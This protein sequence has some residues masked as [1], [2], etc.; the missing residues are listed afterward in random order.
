LKPYSG[1]LWHL[2]YAFEGDFDVTRSGWGRKADAV[3]QREQGEPQRL[4]RYM[5]VWNVG[6]L[7]LQKTFREQVAALR[8]PTALPMR[9]VPNT[10][11]LPRFRLVPRVTFHAGYA[12]ALA[13]AR[14]E[15]WEVARQEHCVRPGRPAATQD[16]GGPS[17]L[18]GVTDRGGRIEA[19]YRAEG[20]AFFVA[21]MTYDPDW[22]A[23]V[24]G[25]RLPAYPTAA[26]QLGVSLPAGEH[27]LV[28]RYR[29]PL[30]GIG[31][32]LSLLALAGGAAALVWPGRRQRMA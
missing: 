4:Y 21:A 27:R 9:V 28:L 24:D 25:R 11:V 8:D 18:L 16:Y 12:A 19:R 23:S 13:A 32:A 20:A 10:Y 1:V 2:A 29:E 15:G 31:V 14:A 30:A 7:L 26:G 5:G 22:R 3:I 6:T 17:R